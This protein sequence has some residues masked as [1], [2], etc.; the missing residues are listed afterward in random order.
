MLIAFCD[1]SSSCL[2]MK[3]NYVSSDASFHLYVIDLGVIF[4][5]TSDG[6]HVVI[7]LDAATFLKV[8]YLKMPL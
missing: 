3:T 7:Y 2:K 5:V 6:S 8:Y 4:H 1:A